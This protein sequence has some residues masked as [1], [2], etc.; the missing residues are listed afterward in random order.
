MKR[1]VK[2]GPTVPVPEKRERCQSSDIRFRVER[3]TRAVGGERQRPNGRRAE[4]KR[5]IEFQWRRRHRQWRGNR[6]AA[7]HRVSRRERRRSQ[8]TLRWQLQT[9]DLR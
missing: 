7:L 5:R 2:G 6:G 1:F 9:S 8:K 4:H 3:A